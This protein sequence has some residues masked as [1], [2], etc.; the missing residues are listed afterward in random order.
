MLFSLAMNWGVY[1]GYV[2]TLA[3]RDNWP[4]KYTGE[5]MRLSNTTFTYIMRIGRKC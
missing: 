5:E 3:D 2:N 1:E 4:D